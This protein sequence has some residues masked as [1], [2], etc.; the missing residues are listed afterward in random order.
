MGAKVGAENAVWCPP[1]AGS[2]VTRTVSSCGGAGGWSLLAYAPGACLTR[3]RFST[4]Q[5][6]PKRGGIEKVS[7]TLEHRE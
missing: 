6:P 7:C 4:K 2:M 1:V 5:S 3:D